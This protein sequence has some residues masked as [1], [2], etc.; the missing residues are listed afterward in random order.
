MSRAIM[1]ICNA[2]IYDGQLQCASEQV[3]MASLNI[4]KWD[5][6]SSEIQSLWLTAAINPSIPVCL[7]DTSKVK[8]KTNYKYTEQTMYLYMQ[9]ENSYEQRTA[10]GIIT[11]QLEAEKVCIIVRTLVKVGG[12]A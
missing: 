7:L 9:C 4:P 6:A 5:L 8:I 12:G 1:D 11:N 10:G 2:L 3:A